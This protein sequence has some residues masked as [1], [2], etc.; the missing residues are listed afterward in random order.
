[1]TRRAW[2]QETGP[3]RSR[4]A[5]GRNAPLP[6]A[7]NSRILLHALPRKR[8]EWEKLPGRGRFCRV[9]GSRYAAKRVRG[10]MG[11][12]P[13]P[14]CGVRTKALRGNSGASPVRFVQRCRRREQSRV[15]P[16]I[17][18]PTA[19][20]IRVKSADGEKLNCET[21][22]KGWLVRSTRGGAEPGKVIAGR[23]GGRFS[24]LPPE[25]GCQ[26]QPATMDGR[27]SATYP[28]ALLRKGAT[29][30]TR[31]F[32]GMTNQV[33]GQAAGVMSGARS[34]HPRASNAWSWKSAAT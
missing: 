30:T 10:A 8:G 18:G 7:R 17:P 12:F 16:T 23:V 24:F 22:V 26:A 2:C 21:P 29:D 15:I 6:T 9:L 32:K 11:A 20:A 28:D 5:S 13:N 4:R 34:R 14:V 31:R 3:P 19:P 25:S 33:R 27:E 1:M